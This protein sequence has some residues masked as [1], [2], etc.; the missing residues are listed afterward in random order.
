[1]IGEKYILPQDDGTELRG[2][3]TSAIVSESEKAIVAAFHLE[4]GRSI[5]TKKPITGEQLDAY[6]ESPETF[7]GVHQHVGKNLKE[8]IE[9]YEWMLETY[10]K[11]PKEKLLEFMAGR[12][13][14]SELREL[15]Q[16]DLAKIYCEGCALSASTKDRGVT[17]PVSSTS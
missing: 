6:K 3:L 9:L 14:I 2:V 4:D 1:M 15:S 11:T 10:R 12:P 7:F 17:K 16:I 5:L 8:P 13:D